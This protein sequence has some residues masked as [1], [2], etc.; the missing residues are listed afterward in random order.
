MDKKTSDER[1]LPRYRG[2]KCLKGLIKTAKNKNKQKYVD[3]CLIKKYYIGEKQT[4]LNIK[5]FS[6]NLSSY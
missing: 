5:C 2:L 6:N 1:V 3:F 4:K